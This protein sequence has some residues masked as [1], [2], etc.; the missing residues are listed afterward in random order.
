M[1]QLILQQILNYFNHFYQEADSYF[2][3]EYV[4]SFYIVNINL[5]FVLFG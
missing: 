2:F 5:Y 1:L 4:L 3:Q